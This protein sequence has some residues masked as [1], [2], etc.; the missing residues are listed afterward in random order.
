V[1]VAAID[2]DTARDALSLIEVEYEELP[3]LFDPLEAVQPQRCWFMKTGV[4][5]RSST[6]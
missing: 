3:G 2:E 4:I 1:A 6:T 5:M